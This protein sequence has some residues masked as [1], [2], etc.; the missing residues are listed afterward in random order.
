MS[1]ECQNWYYPTETKLIYNNNDNLTFICDKKANNM[2]KGSGKT[3]K[4]SPG[5]DVRVPIVGML[6]NVYLLG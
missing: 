4:G 3:F 1:G 6:F 2:L 5:A